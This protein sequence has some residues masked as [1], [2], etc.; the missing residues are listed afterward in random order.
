M[1]IETR[2]MTVH[3][4]RSISG[5]VNSIERMVSEDQYC[6]DIIKQVQAVQA[7]L[8]KVSTLVLDGHLH[9][10]V[11]KAISGDD[12]DERERILSEIVDVFKFAGAKRA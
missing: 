6:I 8:S 4:L 9:S 12:A 11:A 10:C 7:A 2:D 5:H 1:N 3:R